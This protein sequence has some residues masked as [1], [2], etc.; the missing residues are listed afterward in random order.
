[1]VARLVVV[2]VRLVE[3]VERRFEVEPVVRFEEEVFEARL[4]LREMV[5]SVG[6]EVMVTVGDAGGPTIQEG[7]DTSGPPII[8]V[9]AFKSFHIAVEK[10]KAVGHG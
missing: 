9:V 3:A 4:G 1:V 6:K 5:V 10:T 8:S 2:E 7:G